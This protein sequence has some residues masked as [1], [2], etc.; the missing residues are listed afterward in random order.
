MPMPCETVVP[1]V[2]TVRVRILKPPPHV[3]VLVDVVVRVQ[4][5]LSW[6]CAAECKLFREAYEAFKKANKKDKEQRFW[7][8]ARER[9]SGLERETSGGMIVSLSVFPS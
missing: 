5:H 3:T 6:S 8:R 7:V 2:A 9:D 1:W 4:L